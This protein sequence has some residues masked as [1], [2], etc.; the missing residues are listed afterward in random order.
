MPK[1]LISD[2]M[3]PRAAAIFRERGVEVDEITGKTPEELKAIIGQY[4]GLAIRSSTKVTKDILD[5]ATNLKVIGRAGIGVDNVDIPAASSKGVIVMNTPFGNSITT[6]EHAIALM[7]A[8]ARQ[9]PEANAQTQ[10]GLWPKNG[11]MGVEVTGK[12]LGL[13]GAGNIGSIVASRALGLKMKVVAFDPFLTPERAV[14]MG[15]EKADLD[16]LLAKAD[17]ITLHTPLTDQTRNILSKE[18]LAK[19]KKGVRII[20]CARGG[21]IDEAA[22]KEALDS[23]HVAGAALDVFVT[24]PAKESPLFGTPNFI[25]TPHLG[26]STDEAQVNVALQVAE[27]LSDYLLDGGITNALNVPS[28]SAE[29]AP[30]LK[31]Y[32]ALAEEL[33][34]LVGQLEGDRIQ[35][36]SVEVEGH[37]AELNQKPITAAVLAGLMRVYS[38][39]VNMVNA[40][41]LAKERGLDVREVRHDREGDY[42][43]LVRVTVKTEGGDK[44]VAGTLFGN[45][46]ARLVELFGIK[47]EAD[48]A[49]H[50]LYIVNQDAPGFIGRLGSTLGEANV[51][52][53]TFHLG[54]RNQG[55]EAVLLLSVDGVVNETVLNDIC[56]LAGVKTV[57]LLR[58]A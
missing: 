51:N 16:T 8:L 38:D 21:L 55:G 45:A 46:Q 58:F 44:S 3:D 11:F 36:V 19:T 43:T 52:I 12:T 2:K 20:N 40:P 49:G 35:S 22:L 42:Q 34:S 26:A 53:G 48:L 33:G 4:D 14:E 30:K 6:A 1:V 13:I 9:L 57:K 7:F 17:F 25:C 47:V 15:V 28:L 54:R 23:G 10:Q 32:M 18:N 27:Q 56:K 39:T 37:A 29:E 5:H 41:F 31:P 50:M 24:E